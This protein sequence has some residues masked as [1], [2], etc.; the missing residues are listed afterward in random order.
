MLAAFVRAA[1]LELDR[2]VSLPPFPPAPVAAVASVVDQQGLD[3]AHGVCPGVACFALRDL[4]MVS[5]LRRGGNQDVAFTTR[6]GKL[7][8]APFGLRRFATPTVKPA[9][10]HS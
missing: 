2:D 5:D 10:P 4:Q 7:F 3:G 9:P 1:A 8:G 6:R